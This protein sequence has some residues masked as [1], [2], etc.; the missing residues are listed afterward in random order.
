MK[1]RIIISLLLIMSL[2]I[3]GC[4]KLDFELT[5]IGDNTTIKATT[6]DGKTTDSEYFS[7]GKNEHVTVESSLEK[8]ALSLE[9]ISVDVFIHSDDSPDDII[10]TG[11][12]KT[13]NISGHDSATIDLDKGNYIMRITAVGTT[14]GT[15]KVSVGK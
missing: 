9:F 13:L 5:R 12:V 8:G 4:G 2:A 10:E 14:E 15:V 7:V 11:T 3:A 6:T 1:K